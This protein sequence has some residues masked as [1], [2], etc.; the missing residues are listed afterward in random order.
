MTVVA[1]VVVAVVVTSLRR[2]L[3]ERKKYASIGLF[4]SK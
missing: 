3:F 1:V 2:Y 4:E